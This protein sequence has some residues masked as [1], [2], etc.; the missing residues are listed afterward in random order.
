MIL[1]A[2]RVA[3]ERAEGGGARAGLGDHDRHAHAV[4]GGTR[5]DA[6][7]EAA[8]L[9]L[10]SEV[11]GDDG[12]GTSHALGIEYRCHENGDVIVEVVAEEGTLADSL[13]DRGGEQQGDAGS[14]G[15]REA[16]CVWA[17]QVSYEGHCVW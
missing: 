5:S 12:M 14:R 17:T 2:L 13:V 4:A 15:R 3:N 16:H 8:A 9:L 7:A 6:V 10:G 1:L 11:V